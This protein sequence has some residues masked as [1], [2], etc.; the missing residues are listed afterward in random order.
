[1]SLLSAEGQHRSLMAAAV[2]A[3]AAST[4][5]W[6]MYQQRLY[7][8]TATAPVLPQSPPSSPSFYQTIQHLV[9]AHSQRIMAARQHE[10]LLRGLQPVEQQR[11][12]G[13]GKMP[14][15]PN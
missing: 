8:P 15:S 11:E 6:L 4:S 13:E 7:H 3:A 1:M 9:I 10:E 12:N 5:P 14:F 2:A